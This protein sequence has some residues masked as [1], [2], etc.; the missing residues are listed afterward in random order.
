MLGSNI[1]LTLV[2]ESTNIIQHTPSLPCAPWNAGFSMVV[3]TYANP[4]NQKRYHSVGSAVPPRFEVPVW[5]EFVEQQC[6]GVLDSN[7]KQ[8]STSRWL[9]P[10]AKCQPLHSLF[11]WLGLSR[12]MRKSPPPFHLTK[13]RPKIIIDIVTFVQ[14]GPILVINKAITPMNGLIHR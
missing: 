14:G 5:F 12:E 1:W 7:N 10:G 6:Y 11:S 13:T 8:L 4:Q 3:L 9:T 2:E